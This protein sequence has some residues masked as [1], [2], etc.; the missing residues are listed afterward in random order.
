MSFEV[1]LS[2]F[3]LFWSRRCRISDQVI[4]LSK[5]HCKACIYAWMLGKLSSTN[6]R[7]HLAVETCLHNL[8]VAMVIFVLANF[9]SIN[10]LWSEVRLWE[11]EYNID[12]FHVKGIYN[13]LE[14]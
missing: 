12:S 2:V 9:G 13:V 3:E 10:L 4:S 8:M 6:Q 7:L 14:E 1:D 5:V 11:Y